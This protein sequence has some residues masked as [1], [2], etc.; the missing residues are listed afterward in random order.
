VW[1][2]LARPYRLVVDASWNVGLEHYFDTIIVKI[3]LVSNSSAIRF[4]RPQDF[5]WLLLF[6]AL[7]VVSPYRTPLTIGLLVGLGLFQVIEPRVEFFSSRRGTVLSVLVKF[8]VC[9]AVIGST[10][11][12]SSTYYL[13]L[14]LPVVSAA[15]SLGLLA[16][17]AFTVLAILAYLSFLLPVYIDWAHNEL[18][19]QAIGE[20]SLRVI[21]LPV[22]AFLT[23]ELAEAKRVEAR[24]YQVTA[25][26]LGAANES[27]RE[28]EA[29]VRRSD[30]LAA[31]G[32]L[33]AGLAHELRN[34]MGTMRASAEMLLKNTSANDSVTREL[35]GFIAS[36]VDRTNSLI[37]RFLDFARP[38]HLRLAKT[39]VA[40]MIDRA[41]NELERH[42]PPYEV[43]VY[44]NY[45][46]EIPSIE[47]DGEWMERVIYN[48]LLNAAQATSPGGTVTAKTRLIGD[49]VEISVIDRGSGIKKEHLENIFNPFFTT[50]SDG[51]GLGLAIVS[52]IVDEHNGTISVESEP[53]NGTVFR[54][55]LPVN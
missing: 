30:R 28:A 27:L 25:E 22:V 51:V 50:K 4:V 49:R 17:A 8:A 55:Y 15:T 37:T 26:Q 13:I 19:P 7:A 11:A 41:I 23:H 32:Q 31:L 3:A 29:A 43:A 39:N 33:T 21:F 53:G 9:Y 47:L 14:L 1:T 20:L 12:I 46:P 16:T 35:A 5:V 24:R 34:P 40:E 45:S 18:D 54:L 2:Q 52:K 6:S 10:G 36:E 44:R 42:N 38:M 48:L